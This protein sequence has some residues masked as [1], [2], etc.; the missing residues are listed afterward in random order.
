MKIKINRVIKKENKIE[1]NYRQEGLGEFIDDSVIPFYEYGCNIESVPDS[2]AIIPFVANIIP[3][4]FVLNVDIE[5]PCID[6]AFYDCLDDYRKGYQNMI[7]MISFS[8]S[9]K[10]HSVESNNYVPQKNCLLFSGGID[11]TNSLAVNS[12]VID[13]CITI[14]GS[15]IVV[16]NTAGWQIMSAAVKD[17]VH[18]FRKD[19]SVIKSN[20]RTYINECTLGQQI[21]ATKDNWWHAMQHGIA[22]LGQVAPLA[23][24]KKYG[25]I[26]IASSFTKEFHP[27]CASDPRTDNC[28]KCASAITKHDGYEFNRCQKIVNIEK[29]R[30]EL[31][32][33]FNIHVCWESTSGSN[34]GHCEKCLR[35]YL[36]CRAVNCDSSKLG[37]LPSISMQEIKNFYLHKFEFRESNIY[38]YKSI[39]ETIKETYGSNVP[40][41]LKWVLKLKPE[42][43]NHGIYWI[44]KKIFRRAKYGFFK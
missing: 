4:A 10:A 26:Y 41:D 21:V 30:A 24:L 12:E 38:A 11:A 14:W 13:D 17:I 39:Q 28:F 9:V 35:S 36:N 29:K 37:I 34:C 31:N 27:I 18:K 7:P 23:Y 42:K 20:F 43:I 33:V 5:V 44:T 32:T 8:G 22:L 2:I 1:I 25:T 15:D 6:R 19:W 16:D 3:L 40:E